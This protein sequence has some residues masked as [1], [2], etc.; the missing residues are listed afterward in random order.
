[1][2]SLRSSRLL[3]DPEPRTLNPEPLYEVPKVKVSFHS[4][5]IFLSGSRS[6]RCTGVPK[7]ELGNKRGINDY[8]SKNQALIFCLTGFLL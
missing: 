2:E 5:W 4:V 3:L 1:M 7:L 6:F 8:Q